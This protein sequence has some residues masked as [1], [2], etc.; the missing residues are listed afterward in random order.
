[1]YS[2]NGVI[3]VV[4][5]QSYSPVVVVAADSVEISDYQGS[6]FVAHILPISIQAL[7]ILKLIN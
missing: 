3:K 1:M 5:Y 7:V 6:M 2:G 4:R